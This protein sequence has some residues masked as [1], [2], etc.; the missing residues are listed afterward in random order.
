MREL[1]R[2]YRFSHFV[3]PPLQ[4]CK[5]F[6]IVW[7]PNFGFYNVRKFFSNIHLDLGLWESIL[8]CFGYEY[9]QIYIHFNPFFLVYK[10]NVLQIVFKALIPGSRIFA[11]LPPCFI[12]A[13]LIFNTLTLTTNMRV[14]IFSWFRDNNGFLLN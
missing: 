1:G 5:N 13:L 10:Q 7:E 11:C 14:L 9:N 2:G 4:T 8:G 12:P 3:V 6:I